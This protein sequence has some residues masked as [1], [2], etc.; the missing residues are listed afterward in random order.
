MNASPYLNDNALVLPADGHLQALVFFPL[1]VLI[2]YL[3]PVPATFARHKEHARWSILTVWLGCFALTT[4]L[5][6]CIWGRLPALNQGLKDI[7]FNHLIPQ[8][9]APAV[10]ITLTLLAPL[11]I[12]GWTLALHFLAHTQQGRGSYH[13]Q[14]Y[15]VLVIATPPVLLLIATTLLLSIAP[16][17]A[18]QLRLPLTAM[19][20]LLTLYSFLLCLPSLMGV[21]QLSRG[22]AIICLVTVLTVALLLVFFTDLFSSHNTSDGGGGGRSFKKP[23]NW[24]ARYCPHCGFSLQVYDRLHD[25]PTHICPRCGQPLS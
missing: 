15:S 25:T 1:Q 3:W 19:A 8:P 21:Q 13:T 11:L 16:N 14:L 12:L 24:H 17:M 7:S 9:L 10:V 18:T 4:G 20:I 6:A 5:G 22:K 2:T 23:K